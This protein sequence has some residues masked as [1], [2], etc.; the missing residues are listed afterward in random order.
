MALFFFF[1][2]LLQFKWRLESLAINLWSLCWK[3]DLGCGRWATC[4]LSRSVSPK[5]TSWSAHCCMWGKW[6]LMLRMSPCLL[7]TRSVWADCSVDS[8]AA[9]KFSKNDFFFCHR[10][11][12]LAG[13]KSERFAASRFLNLKKKNRRNPGFSVFSVICGNVPV[14]SGIFEMGLFEVLVSREY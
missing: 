2:V 13:K 1:A 7:Q 14:G 9:L 8:A 10:F 3:A 6:C 11:F 12:Y 4:C 5:V